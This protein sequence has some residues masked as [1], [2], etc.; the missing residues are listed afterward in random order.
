MSLVRYFSL[1][2]C[3]SLVVLDNAFGGVARLGLSGGRG[4]VERGQ[5]VS[6][7]GENWGAGFSLLEGTYQI[8]QA[9]RAYDPSDENQVL[10][11]P[12]DEDALA[13]AVLICTECGAGGMSFFLDHGFYYRALGSGTLYRFGI[14]GEFAQLDTAS[15]IRLS[16]E[17]ESCPQHIQ[18]WKRH[19][20]ISAIIGIDVILSRFVM[21][22]FYSGISGLGFGVGYNF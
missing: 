5:Y 20:Q 6:V 21:Y 18:S 1:I 2:L 15:I 3:F 12:A 7:Y 22:G 11:Y 19:E 17:N 9:F 16:C 4:E 13:G 14:G 10:G 8:K